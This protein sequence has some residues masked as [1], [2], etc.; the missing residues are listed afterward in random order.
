[1][2]R[3]SPEFRAMMGGRENDSDGFGY[4]Y[5]RFNT[6]INARR[7][8]QLIRRCKRRDKR[9]VRRKE[10]RFEDKQNNCE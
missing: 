8:K 9:A 7:Q 6:Y 1:M 10:Q 2:G 4:N 5:G 3:K